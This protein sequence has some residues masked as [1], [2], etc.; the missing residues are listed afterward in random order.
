MMR[1]LVIALSTLL[2]LA[3]SAHAQVSV[4][5]EIPGIS[6]G[7]NM[8]VYPELVQVPG[9]P[10]YYD[11]NASSNYFFYDGAYWVYWRDAWYESDWYNGPW[12]L[13]SPDDVPL[14]VLRVPVQYYRQAPAFFHGWRADAA[15]RWGE[16]WG[17]GWEEHHRGWDQW[18]HRS[19]PVAAPLPDYQRRYSGDRYPK[20]AEQQHALRAEHYN[21]KPREAV[22]QQLFQRQFQ[23]QRQATQHQ[24]QPQQQAT[25]HQFQP[26][27]QATQHQTQPQQQ[28]AQHRALPQQ[29]GPRE[30]GRAPRH[31]K[32]EDQ[33]REHR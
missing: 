33:G 5:I 13:V 6:I 29:A 11:P 32:D 22:T 21:Y 31:N 10:V 26:Q 20:A 18:D 15:P 28:V 1:Y 2:G 19:P 9:Y 4:G 24:A 12:Q 27:Q 30:Q 23:P 16:H 25:Q 7:I 17:R 3:S 14:F 8:P